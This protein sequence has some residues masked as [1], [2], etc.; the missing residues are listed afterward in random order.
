MSNLREKKILIIDDDVELLKMMELSFS[1]TEA[2]I[3]TA[4]GGQEGLRLFYTYQ[5]DLVILD[6]MMPEMDGMQVCQNIRQLSD[7]PIII[8]TALNTDETLI[9]GL[10]CGADDYVTKPVSHQALLARTRAVL[11]RTEM[12]PPP[13]AAAFYSDD[14]LT[15]DLENRRV[16]VEG[17]NVK[18]S[19]TEYHLLAC[20]LENAGR[21]PTNEQILSYVWGEEYRANIDYVHVYLSRLRRKLEKDPQQPIYLVTERG[22]GYRFEKQPP[23]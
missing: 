6:L 4:T 18:L 2:Q 12:P 10:D 19:A 15:I 3:Y 11:R 16:F 7:T 21:I 20:L 23:A 13:R 8:L 22:V 14:Y 17:E 9:R 5:P 1:R